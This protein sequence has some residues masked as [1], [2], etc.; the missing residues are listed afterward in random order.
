M[1][2]RRTAAFRRTRDFRT[3]LETQ[4]TMIERRHRE[5]RV[6]LGLLLLV[7][8]STASH[9][10]GASDVSVV[11]KTWYSA[12]EAHL[13]E[14]F[15]PIL[16]C[17]MERNRDSA[18]S[19]QERCNN[20]A[21]SDSQLADVGR[22]VTAESRFIY[23]VRLR[24]VG[25]QEIVGISWRYEFRHPRTNE[26]L[27]SHEFFSKTRLRPGDSAIFAERSFRPPSATIPA[28]LLELKGTNSYSEFVRI[29]A[30]EYAP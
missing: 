3:N 30:V 10:S 1:T 9:A 4:R 6:L 24:N 21:R 11:E 15:N 7:S 13:D 5:L 17:G 19:R 22:N 27:G 28:E 2:D 25:R 20:F 8:G 23:Q 26:M 12:S 18:R 29:V 16:V 14:F